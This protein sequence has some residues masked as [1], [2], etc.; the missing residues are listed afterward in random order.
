MHIIITGG[1][2]AGL[3]TYLSLTKSLP[4]SIPYTITL[5]ESHR[6]RSTPSPSQHHTFDS[7]SAST[8]IVGGGLGVSP[9]GMRVLRSLSPSLHAAVSSQGFPCEHFVFMG[10]NGW[11]LGVQRTGDQG[12]YEGHEG[13]EEVCVSSSREGLW[14]CL[15]REVGEGAVRYRKVVGVEV[16]GDGG[17]KVVRFEDGGSEECDVLVGADGVRSV[18]RGALFGDGE[19]MGPRY[20]GASGIGGFINTEL[21]ARVLDNKAMVFTFGGSGFF[22]YGSGGPPEAKSLMWWSTFETDDLPSRENLDRDE[23][24]AEMRKRHANSVDPVI[25][26][27]IAKAEVESIYPTWVL[28]DLPHWGENGIV[29]VGDAAHALSP[30][31]GQGASQALEDAQTLSLLLAATLKRA[32]DA[33]AEG[34]E[35]EEKERTAVAVSLKLFYSIRA[36][37]VKAIAERG[38]KMDQ[39][40]KKMSWIE[41][42]GM[43]CFFWLMMHVAPLRKLALGDVNTQLYGWSAE[44][45]VEKALASVEL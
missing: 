9:N 1:G 2:I 26:D 21:P 45:E 11:T 33:G 29:L 44:A 32:Y 34:G 16:R 19:G 41:E 17:K 22:G 37:R 25:R 40:K 3:A 36:P 31:T 38:R 24:K 6:P 14:R 28:P 5:Y 35:L 27:I 43:Y 12:G 30:T 18:V 15:M 23:I 8:A 7:L 10:E 13:R 42:Y 20:T 39:Q 4:P